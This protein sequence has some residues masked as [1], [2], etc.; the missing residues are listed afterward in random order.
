M[1]GHRP[2]PVWLHFIKRKW[3]FHHA[4][5]CYSR[6]DRSILFFISC[7]NYQSIIDLIYKIWPFHQNLTCY[8]HLS[9][10]LFFFN[11]HKKI[12]LWLADFRVSVPQCSAWASANTGLAAN[13]SR[14]NSLFTFHNVSHYSRL[15]K[16]IC[17]SSH[18]K[19]INGYW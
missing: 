6:L 19:I 5:T 18:V 4:L 11:V 16:S 1:Q 3:P 2:I 10:Y 15:Y 7:R 13:S 9:R 17:F 8:L 14:E 12:N